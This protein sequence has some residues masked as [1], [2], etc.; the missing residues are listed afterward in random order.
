MATN[1]TYYRLVKPNYDE[2][3]DI[4][5]INA[6]MDK[7]DTQMKNNANGVGQAKELVSDVYSGST[8]YSVGDY[9]IYDNKLYRCITGITTAEA[10]DSAKW[11]ETKVGEE[12][13]K[14]SNPLKGKKVMFFGDSITYTE[15]CY[16]KP[17]L[18]NTGMIQVENFAV[19]GAWLT[20]YDGVVLDGNP[21]TEANNTVPN[22]VQKMLN[23]SYDTPD[24][25]IV[26]A[27]TNGTYTTFADGLVEAQFTDGTAYIDVDTCDLL[28]A[29]GAM[30]WIYEK[31]LSVYPN[32]MIFFATPIQAAPSLR[33]YA[34]IVARRDII[35]KIANRMSAN[36]IDAFA[37]SGI[38]GRYEVGYAN[39][40]YL[41][42]GL[43]PNEE[44]GKLL[45]KCYQ[46]ELEKVMH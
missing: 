5:V 24:I 10:F 28:K 33:T 36:I 9:C 20:N 19:N 12:V 32:A 29:S 16:R 37:Y 15:R 31:I 39:G 25:V 18:E 38:Y 46:S 1:T 6:N 43:H 35:I 8:T 11:Q 14:L 30:R 41:S 40:K 21:T 22:Q 42:D 23:G 26:S 2:I 4:E 3:A 34:N 27:G 45:A 13:R 7:I 44:G 17:L